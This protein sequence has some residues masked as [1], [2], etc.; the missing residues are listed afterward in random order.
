[1]P[2][3]NWWSLQPDE[4]LFHYCCIITSPSM[5]SLFIHVNFSLGE[6]AFAFC[7]DSRRWD[8]QDYQMQI[9][10]L[11]SAQYCSSSEKENKI[12]WK[13]SLH[14]HGSGNQMAIPDWLYMVTW[15]VS[16]S[17]DSIIWLLLISA[18]SNDVLYYP[19]VSHRYLTSI[20]FKSYH[21]ILLGKYMLFYIWIL[22]ENRL[23]GL[24]IDNRN[25]VFLLT[26]S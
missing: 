4:K 22:R 2:I 17:Y 19:I 20:L 13:R 12:H 9:D 1:M 7:V 6:F 3:N 10:T 8:T 18:K 5:N 24:R 25:I 15:L 16:S 21:H 26:E 11:I 14:S 23:F